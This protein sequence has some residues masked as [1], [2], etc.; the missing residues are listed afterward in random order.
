MQRPSEK[1]SESPQQV[2]PEIYREALTRL[3]RLFFNDQALAREAVS[4]TYLKLHGRKSGTPIKDVKAYLRKALE[5]QLQDVLKEHLKH[6]QPL[7]QPV[8][9]IGVSIPTV[10]GNVEVEVKDVNAEHAVSFP[11]EA[12]ILFDRLRR[13]LPVFDK[14]DQ[15]VLIHDILRQMYKLGFIGEEPMPDKELALNLGFPSPSA[16]STRRQRLKKELR[17]IVGY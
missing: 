2:D 8:Q 17:E 10:R 16:L 9:R 14:R 3:A 6:T 1:Q 12:L 7:G 13:A 5:S 15:A 11:V 4:R